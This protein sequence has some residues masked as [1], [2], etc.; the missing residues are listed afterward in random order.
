MDEIRRFWKP[1]MGHGALN[2]IK[3]GKK[4]PWDIVESSMTK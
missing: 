4:M 1:R 2:M 3:E